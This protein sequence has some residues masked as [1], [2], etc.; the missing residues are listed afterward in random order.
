VIGLTG[1]VATGKSSVS[2]VLE[3]N[4]FE[5]IDADK[6]SREVSLFI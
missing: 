5:I 6:I 4:G 1:G 3:E 2:T